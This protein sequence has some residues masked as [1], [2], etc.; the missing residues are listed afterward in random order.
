MEARAYWKAKETMGEQVSIEKSTL[1]QVRDYF[2]DVRTEM[3]RV[4]WPSKQEI[5][6]TT[7]MVLITTF[8]FGFYFWIC[9]QVFSLAVSRILRHFLHG[10]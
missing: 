8:L 3:K 9:D 2:S 10:G 7:V 4:T 5:Y 6:G 1:L